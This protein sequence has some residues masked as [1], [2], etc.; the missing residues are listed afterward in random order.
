MKSCLR[1]P[2]IVLLAVVAAWAQP[3]NSSSRTI[4]VRGE[5]VSSAALTNGL[6]VELSG[7]GT[8]FTDTAS[9]NSDSTFEFRS[10]TVGTHELRVLAANG[11]LLHQEMVS[12]SG[13]NQTLSIHLSDSTSANRSKDSTISL[14]QLRHKVP[15]AAQKAFQKGEQAASKGNLDQARSLFEQAVTIDPEF[16]DAHNELGAANA[17][18]HNLPAAAGEFQKA[19]DLVPEHRLAL[20]NLSIVL[21]QMKRFHE[22][23]EVARRALQIVPADG[24]IHYILAVSLMSEHGDVDEIIRHFERAAGD[25]PAAHVTAAELLAERGRSEEAVREL[26]DFLQ[27]APAGD[28]LRPKAE[29]RLA[30]LRK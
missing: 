5:I 11:Q 24:R 10:A 17:G 7:D 9:V 23:G 1:F 25:V 14:Q 4:T 16:A 6:T 3:S 15:S 18:L 26:E 28:S 2:A 30:E 19:I 13:P 29:A 27:A 12:I 20:P 22:A 8:G 21:A